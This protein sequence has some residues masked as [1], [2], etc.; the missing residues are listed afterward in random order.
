[1]LP[2]LSL[3][4]ISGQTAMHT[5]PYSLRHTVTYS[6]AFSMKPAELHDFGSYDSIITETSNSDKYINMSDS[7]TNMNNVENEDGGYVNSKIWKP[8]EINR[9]TDSRGRIH[10]NELNYGKEIRVFVSDNEYELETCK[11]YILLPSTIYTEIRKSRLKAHVGD[12]VVVQKSGDV[13]L[14][15]TNKNKYVK[16]FIKRD[17]KL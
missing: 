15:K 6:M 10:V 11:H 16:V 5:A 7:I 12:P 1:M 8:I 2:V 4:N 13:W 14:G 17:D 9:K 3:N